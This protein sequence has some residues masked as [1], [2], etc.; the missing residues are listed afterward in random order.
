V[1]AFPLYHLFRALPPTSL[2]LH[3]SLPYR[4]SLS[5]PRLAVPTPPAAPYSCRPSSTHQRCVWSPGAHT[6]AVR[7]A[8]A[9]GSSRSAECASSSVSRSDT[10]S[11]LSSECAGLHPP[12]LAR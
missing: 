10:T 4:P 3:S 12:P 7:G 6:C 11:S 9:A 2:A 5:S 1:L 8:A